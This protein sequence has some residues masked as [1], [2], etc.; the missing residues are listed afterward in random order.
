MGNEIETAKQSVLSEV[1]AANG[2]LTDKQFDSI[3]ENARGK[4]S[5][6][7]AFPPLW[8][9]CANTDK[10]HAFHV[11]AAHLLMRDGELGHKNGQYVCI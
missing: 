10:S 5:K 4:R 6:Y 2:I 3:F 7:L 8:F 1:K 9:I 11:H